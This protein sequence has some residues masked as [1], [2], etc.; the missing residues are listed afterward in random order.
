MELPRGELIMESVGEGA[1][2]FTSTPPA[3]ANAPTPSADGPVCEFDEAALANAAEAIDVCDES[4]HEETFSDE[5]VSAKSERGRGG[6]PIAQ[7]EESRYARRLRARHGRR[8]SA[9]R[10]RRDRGP[11]RLRPGAPSDGRFRS[12]RRTHAIHLNVQPA[13]TG[14][15]KTRRPGNAARITLMPMDKI[16]PTLYLEP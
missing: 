8:A 5:S 7:R 3:P 1:T 10:S 14:E 4:I 16:S 15:V 12:S 11:K 13:Q 6:R 2:A 9:I